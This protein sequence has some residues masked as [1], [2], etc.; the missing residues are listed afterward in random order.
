MIRFKVSS[1]EK[2]VDGS[3]VLLEMIGDAYA[4]RDDH[5]CWPMPVMICALYQPYDDGPWVN[6]DLGGLDVLLFILFAS[7][8]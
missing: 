1:S 5:Q 2:L 7:D 6:D 4:G 8:F 3:N